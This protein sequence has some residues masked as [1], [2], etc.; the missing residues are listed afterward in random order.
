MTPK[1]WTPPDD[2]DPSDILNSAVRDTRAGSHEQALA[3]FLWFHQNALQYELGLSGVRLSFAL[4]YWLNLAAV[5]PPARDAFVLVRDRTEAAFRQD[6]PNFNLFHDIASLNERLGE[7][8]RT[9]DLF[10]SVAASDHSAA[11]LLYHVAEPHLVA[12]GRFHA[13]EPFLNPVRRMSLAAECYRLSKNFEDA[14]P[15]R[16]IPIPKLARKHYSQNVAT[17]VALLVLNDRPH[18]ADAA[19]KTALQVLDDPE[20]RLIMDAAMTGHLPDCRLH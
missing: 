20:F 11:Q 17:L 19:Y 9:A 7:G 15:E 5:Y 16:G 3:K 10:T 1:A 13:C 4:A 6:Y 8:I 14:R 2:P 18:D 12:A